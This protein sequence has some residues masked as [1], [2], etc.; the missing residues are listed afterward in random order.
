MKPTSLTK[1]LESL[2]RLKFIKREPLITREKSKRVYYSVNDNFLHFWFR[3]F[4]KTGS[5]VESGEKE[6]IEEILRRDL[7][8]FF[9]EKFEELIRI[10][11]QKFFPNIEKV[12]KWRGFGKEQKS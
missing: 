9:G 1:Y 7:N 11:I 8:S 6:K 2:L 5:L 4:T 10:N 3:L 12:G